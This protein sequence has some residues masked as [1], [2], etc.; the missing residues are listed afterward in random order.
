[1]EKAKIE[2]INQLAKKKKRE[3]LTDAEQ[4]EQDK[5][6]KEYISEF[7]VGLKSQLDNMVIEK[8]DGT[9]INVKDLKKKS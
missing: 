6:R 4:K 7:R 5:L 1:M 8:P 9:T 2:R 3:G